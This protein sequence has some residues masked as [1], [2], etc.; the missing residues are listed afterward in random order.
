MSQSHPHILWEILSTAVLPVPP[1]HAAAL[2]GAEKSLPHEEDL[3]NIY[4][5]FLYLGIS[6]PR[7]Q[8]GCVKIILFRNLWGK[9]NSGKWKP[10]ETAGY[11]IT[12]N[13]NTETWKRKTK[14]VR[15]CRWNCSFLKQ[16]RWQ[17]INVL[18]GCKVR[19][20]ASISFHWHWAQTQHN[21]TDLSGV[22]RCKFCL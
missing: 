22:T 4:N 17:G 21:S 2:Q 7:Q 12:G 15:G 5:V 6:L 13:Y 20:R 19:A 11:N 18:Q 10:T 16:K 3:I 14:A 1:T 9:A 8:R